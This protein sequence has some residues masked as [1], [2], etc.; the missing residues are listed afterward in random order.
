MLNGL[1]VLSLVLCVATVALWVRSHW[2]AYYLQ[3]ARV[4]HKG[5]LCTGRTAEFYISPGAFAV[6]GSSFQT[7]ELDQY[8]LEPVVKHSPQFSSWQTGGLDVP[9]YAPGISTVE[10]RYAGFEIW[11]DPN[12]PVWGSIREVRLPWPRAGLVMPFW[13]LAAVF[14]VLPLVLTAKVRRANRDK[15]AGLCAVCRYDLRGNVSGVCSECGTVIQK[16]DQAK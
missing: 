15:R 1:M 10:K 9:V 13:A 14:A 3:F 5:E 16:V 8:E 12:T 7:F 2:T 6:S 4:K 11:Y